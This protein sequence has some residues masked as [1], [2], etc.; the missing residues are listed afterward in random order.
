MAVHSPRR[1]VQIE[2]RI[3]SANTPLLWNRRRTTFTRHPAES[4]ASIC[5]AGMAGRR[6]GARQFSHTCELAAGPRRARAALKSRSGS[7]TPRL[8]PAA[9][10]RST[11]GC[12]RSI[13]P[14]GFFR[15]L[16]L[17]SKAPTWPLKWRQHHVPAYA[18]FGVVEKLVSQW[19]QERGVPER[20]RRIDERW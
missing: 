10:T 5:W 13:C 19:K 1:W 4:W 16:I 12:G 20:R 2:C 3:G 6:D 11:W 14:W 15:S 7:R 8:R 18:I 9:W 17:N